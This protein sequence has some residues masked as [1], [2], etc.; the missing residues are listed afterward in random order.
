MPVVGFMPVVWRRASD[1][2]GMIGGCLGFFLCLLQLQWLEGKLKKG[3]TVSV[4]KPAS[5]GE[6]NFLK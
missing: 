2:Y 1:L 6:L 5:S 3:D 4:N